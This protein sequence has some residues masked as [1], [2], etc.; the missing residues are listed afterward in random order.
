MK[1]NTATA[2]SSPLRPRNL[3]I[4]A[5]RGVAALSVMLFHFTAWYAKSPVDGILQLDN[6]VHAPHFLFYFGDLGV[7]LFFMIS[8]Y[9]ITESS[10]HRKKIAS[11]VYRRFTRL[12][13]LYWCSIIFAVMCYLPSN[14]RTVTYDP[15]WLTI[16][17]NF[18]ML[19]TSVNVRNV[20][21]AYWTLYIELQF[22]SFVALALAT[23]RIK[24]FPLQVLGLTSAYAI[25]TAFRC[26]D[27][28]PGI[29]R[30]KSAFPLVVFLNYF[31][32]GI[33]V[34]TL[35]KSELSKKHALAALVLSC[36]FL[37]IRPSYNP[38][39][40]LAIFLVFWAACEQKLTFLENRLLVSLGT[41][42]YAL[43]LVHGPCGYTMLNHL[44]QHLQVDLLIAA[45]VLTSIMVAALFTFA[46]EKPAGNFLRQAARTTNTR[47]S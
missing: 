33:W 13:P 27:W 47:D 11:F 35:Q 6:F 42:S 30:I 37:F 32:L 45:A 4:D 2:T 25:A 7:P 1:P 20:N 29:W 10:E 44:Q 41:I 8:G 46:V 36:V 12:Y 39:A 16:A 40:V 14:G 38:L 17:I 15:E 21:E 9:V 28:I 34:R 43:Y 26:W 3:Q 24:Q 5:L 19:Q 31:A 18:S 22:Y 23:R